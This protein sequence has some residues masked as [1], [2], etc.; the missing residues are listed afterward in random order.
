[1]CGTTRK[2]SS[3][4]PTAMM[5]STCCPG[6]VTCFTTLAQAASEIDLPARHS[7]VATRI[8]LSAGVNRSEF[9]FRLRGR[10]RRASIGHGVV[11]TGAPTP[12]L[13][14]VSPPGDYA[15][16]N[17]NHIPDGTH[18]GC[19]N[20]RSRTSGLQLLV[21]PTSNQIYAVLLIDGPAIT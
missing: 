4:C 17:S 21:S 13:L 6:S 18:R 10:R 16:L 11:S 8:A 1:G 7:S 3:S 2:T 9:R 5:N 14:W 20:G 19:E 12:G 15:F